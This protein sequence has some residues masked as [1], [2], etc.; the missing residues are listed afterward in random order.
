MEEVEERE[1]MTEEEVMGTLE[2]LTLL[3]QL[4]LDMVIILLCRTLQVGT[5][6]VRIQI[7]LVEL[8]NGSLRSSWMDQ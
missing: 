6:T 3:L 7:Q 8:Q 2:N 5:T 1:D 4:E